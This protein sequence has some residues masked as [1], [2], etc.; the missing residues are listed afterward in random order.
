MTA[1]FIGIGVAL[2]AF[3]MGWGWSVLMS[4]LRVRHSNP[5]DEH[6]KYN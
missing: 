3:L 2:I 4:L 1:F 5:F 6:E